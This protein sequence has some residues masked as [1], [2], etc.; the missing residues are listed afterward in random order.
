MGNQNDSSSNKNSN[1]D[2]SNSK[3]SK[4]YYVID[5]KIK[6]SAYNLEEELLSKFCS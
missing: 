1:K 3:D 5:E 2:I 6:A 4:T